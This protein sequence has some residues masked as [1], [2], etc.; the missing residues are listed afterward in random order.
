LDVLLQALTVQG[1]L[2]AYEARQRFYEIGSLS[3]LNELQ[4]LLS[5][6]GDPSI[7]ARPASVNG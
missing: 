7:V 1:S 6:A 5:V 2:H 4:E 3:G